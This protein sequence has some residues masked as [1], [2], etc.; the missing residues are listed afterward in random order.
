MLLFVEKLSHGH[1]TLRLNSYERG[2]TQTISGT[3]LATEEAEND[4]SL[5]S[6]HGKMCYVNSKSHVSRFETN[7]RKHKR[8]ILRLRGVYFMDIDGVNAIDEIIDIVEGRGQQILI[9]GAGGE[10]E[11]MLAQLSEGYKR[12][13]EKGLVFNK[14]QEA[15]AYLH[16][17]RSDVK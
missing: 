4:F 14:S 9:S 8:I 7:F 10:P 1:F 17:H 11:S 13:M 2:N 5:Y 12:L 15:I 6:I 16:K 3:E